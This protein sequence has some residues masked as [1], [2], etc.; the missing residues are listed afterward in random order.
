MQFDLTTSPDLR[1]ALD[2]LTTPRDG[3]TPASPATDW[4]AW[5]EAQIGGMAKVADPH[6][7]NLVARCSPDISEANCFLFA[8]RV[9][10][11]DIAAYVCGN[12]VYFGPKFMAHLEKVRLATK[13]KAGLNEAQNGDLVIYYRDGKPEHAG[14][15]R[16]GK[17]ISK[18]G[19]GHV[20]CHPIGEVPA[21]Y[22]GTAAIF[23]RPQRVTQIYQRW[24]DDHG[25]GP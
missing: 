24:A 21:S 5:L 12:L 11:A 2:D 14:T 20:W 15:W 18:W 17:V 10:P 25:V 6:T 7:V 4:D 3:L 13:E 16:A 8:L 23:K 19:L 1:K 22:G 9:K